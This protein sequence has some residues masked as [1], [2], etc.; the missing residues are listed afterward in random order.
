MK[1][2][3]L[4]CLQLKSAGLI[5]IQNYLKQNGYDVTINQVEN[6]INCLVAAGNVGFSAGQYMAINK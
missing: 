6:E 2:L 1:K 4:K 5:T 3:I